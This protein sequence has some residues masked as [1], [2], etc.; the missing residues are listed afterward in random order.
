MLV[1][2]IVQNRAR[3][4]DLSGTGAFQYGGRWNSK[5]TYMLYTSENSSL[6]YLESLVH[7]DPLDLPPH[8]FILTIE[9]NDRS[10]LLMVPD[11]AYPAGWLQPGLH[12]NK[13]MGDRYMAENKYIGIKVR[14]AVNT[15]E[16]NCLLNPLFPDFKNLVT[17]VAV[18]E[19][20]MDRRLRK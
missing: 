2:R 7:F 4:H 3:T 16:Y 6:A 14:S 10:P 18:H 11:S 13:E 17:V 20:E 19:V 8:L 15:M 5:G 1:Y 12:E 9:V